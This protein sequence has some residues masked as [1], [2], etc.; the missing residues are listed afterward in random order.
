[1]WHGLAVVMALALLA[2]S[3]PPSRRNRASARRG[4]AGGGPRAPLETVAIGTSGPVA[5]WLPA[6]LA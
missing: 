4:R 3:Q 5:S 6:Q 2:C 1:M